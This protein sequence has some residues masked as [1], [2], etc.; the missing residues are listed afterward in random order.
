MVSTYKN[1]EFVIGD[2]VFYQG[3]EIF[4]PHKRFIGV[5]VGVPDDGYADHTYYIFWF[6]SRLTTR[7]HCDN[8]TLVYEK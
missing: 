7:L 3:F 4:E 1:K 6:D 2:L 8:I 5:V